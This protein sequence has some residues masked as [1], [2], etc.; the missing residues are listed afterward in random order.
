M[1]N[2]SQLLV[3]LTKLLKRLEKDMR[4]A[5]KELHFERAAELRDAISALKSAPGGKNP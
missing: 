1:I 3:D 5:A 2:A 4:K